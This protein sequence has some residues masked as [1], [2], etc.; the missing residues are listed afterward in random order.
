VLADGA[1]DRW[2]IAEPKR[3][4]P[5][6][7]SRKASHWDV[8]AHAMPGTMVHLTECSIESYGTFVVAAAAE[9]RLALPRVTVK[10][11][12]RRA[13]KLMLKLNLLCSEHRWAFEEPD[14][15]MG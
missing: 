7:E 8:C 9:A 12:R 3:S 5:D 4:F 11:R 2:P 15:P 1:S 10:A 6:A 13:E 14:R